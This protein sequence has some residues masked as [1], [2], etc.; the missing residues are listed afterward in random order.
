LVLAAIGEVKTPNSEWMKAG[1]SKKNIDEVAGAL[2]GL[3]KDLK[4]NNRQV[5]TALPEYEI[6][7]RLV[8][9]PPL[10]ETE[11]KDALKFEA[12]TFVPYPWTK[13]QLIMK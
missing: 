6:V 4:I 8:S 1:V 3:V 2:K 9:L 12:E 5:V 13:C 7:S 11:I 10:K